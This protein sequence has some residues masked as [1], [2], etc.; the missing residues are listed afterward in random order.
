MRS[1]YRVALV[2]GIALAGV[3]AVLASFGG[4]EAEAN[5]DEPQPGV[6]SE[7]PLDTDPLSAEELRAQEVDVYTQPILELLEEEYPDVYGGARVDYESNIFTI[8]GR[9]ETPP[10]EVQALME[11]VP[12]DLINVE[13]R[14]AAFS[15]QEIIAARNALPELEGAWLIGPS[16]EATSLMVWVSTDTNT[17]S[18]PTEINGVPVEYVAEDGQLEPASS[19]H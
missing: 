17:E 10:D 11:A 18:Y 15:H 13:W 2:S 16:P 14:S 8:S 9:S 1:R 12:S 6:E 5:P 7:V 19:K 4:V 3:V